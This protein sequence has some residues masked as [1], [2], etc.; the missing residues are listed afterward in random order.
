MI[1]SQNVPHNRP[2]NVGAYA[3]RST[4]GNL[5]RRSAA[6]V[7]ANAGKLI[8][9][10]FTVAVQSGCGNASGYADSDYAEA[11]ASVIEN[12]GEL[13][14]GSDIVMTVRKPDAQDV[15]ALKQGALYISF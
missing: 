2:I 3:N 1:R 13:L 4:E 12:R 6:I 9:Q 15:G 5:A 7:P 8:K 11:G 14:A 10:G